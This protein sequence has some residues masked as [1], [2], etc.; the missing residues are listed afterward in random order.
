[1]TPFGRLHYFA[2]ADEM[3]IAEAEAF[4]RSMAR[5]QL[6]T[7]A[8]QIARSNKTALDD[9]FAELPGA[10]GY[11]FDARSTW[12]AWPAARRL[13]APFGKRQD[14][15]PMYLNLRH[16]SEDDYLRELPG[17]SGIVG[18]GPHVTITGKTGS[19]KSKWIHAVVLNFSVRHS[20]DELQFILV[21][22]KGGVEL[23]PLEKLPNVHGVLTNETSNQ[24]FLPRFADL[25]MGE[26]E[27]RYA[28]LNEAGFADAAVYEQARRRGAALPPLPALVM[29]VDEFNT[30]LTNHS[31]YAPIFDEWAR[32]GRA[33]DCHMIIG[34]QSMNLGGVKNVLDNTHTK[35]ALLCSPDDSRTQLGTTIASEILKTEHGTGYVREESGLV[36]WRSVHVGAPY[37]PKPKAKRRGPADVPVY[38]LPGPRLLTVDDDELPPLAPPSSPEPAPELDDVELDRTLQDYVIEQLVAAGGDVGRK[39]WLPPVHELGRPSLGDLVD[40]VTEAR[41][42]IAGAQWH[43]HYGEARL[44][45]HLWAPIGRVDLPREHKHETAV[46]RLDQQGGY[47]GITGSTQS[48]RSTAVQALLLSLAMQFTP[49]QVQFFGLGSA[50]LGLDLGHVAGSA[51]MKDEEN[52]MRVFDTVVEL[53]QERTRMFS[54]HK[55][56]AVEEFRELLDA[57][58]L[59]FDDGYGEVFVV[60]DSLDDFDTTYPR[61]DDQLKFL[62]STAAAVG[63]H[64][65]GTGGSMLKTRYAERINL[66]IEMRLADPTMSSM[67]NN[68]RLSAA[69]PENMPGAG[70]IQ[71]RGGAAQFLTAEP[72]AAAGGSRADLVA[73]INR[74]GSQYGSAIRMN[75]LP[76]EITLSEVRA[77]PSAPTDRSKVAFGLKQSDMTPAVWDYRHTPHLMVIGQ[78]EAGRTT[79]LKT[80]V[81]QIM[82]TH[83]PETEAL[84]ILFDPQRTMLGVIPEDEGNKYA[85]RYHQS[86]E[87]MAKDMRDFAQGLLAARRPKEALSQRALAEGVGYTGPEFFIIVD[88]MHVTPDQHAMLGNYFLLPLIEDL[89]SAA[90]MGFHLIL[91]TTSKGY[92]GPFTGNPAVRKMMASGQP[93]LVLAADKWD[94]DLYSVQPTALPPGRGFYVRPGENELV[95]VALPQ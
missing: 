13:E 54:L 7:E 78:P 58:Q 9:F 82:D 30:L 74:V 5:Y 17:F 3:S 75:Q 21:D 14:G 63:V 95:Q 67:T 85:A 47:V 73:E 55:I 1:M 43:Q 40:E 2:T 33:L 86:P 34:G 39:I 49:K 48:G 69:V 93:G 77:L 31:E 92:M 72:S 52:A 35:Y 42:G 80:L 64:V 22:F 59:P 12:E 87:S 32:Q 65:V 89:G 23:K 6:S 57:G 68:R 10:N 62:L 44:S 84:F 51:L 88:D 90:Q 53:V 28:I 27:K 38:E 71:H 56:G 16:S 45:K 19:G 76:R 66:R 4:A 36:R 8:E 15:T 20:P 29:V 83:A 81:K 70:L 60:I 50:L 79:M 41:T 37:R 18:G 46:W 26:I 24:T 11:A 91:T 94:V 25:M 61:L